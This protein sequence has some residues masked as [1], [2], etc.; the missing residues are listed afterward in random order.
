MKAGRRT[1]PLGGSDVVATLKVQSADRLA[2]GRNTRMS[3]TVGPISIVS[4]D[5]T[6]ATPLVSRPATKAA[7]RAVRQNSVLEPPERQRP[8]MGR[9]PARTPIP[10]PGQASE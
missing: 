9:G 3:P 5:A 6:V 10:E 2:P 4:A 8:L 1:Q 7:I